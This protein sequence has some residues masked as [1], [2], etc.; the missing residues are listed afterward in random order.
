MEFRVEGNYV[1]QVSDYTIQQ[2]ATPLAAGDSFGGT[3]TVS[4]SIA[5][6]DPEIPHRK[7]T[8]SR[9]LLDSGRNILRGKSYTLTT[10]WGVMYGRIESVS[11]DSDGLLQISAFT[12]LNKLNSFNVQAKPFVGTLGDLIRYYCSLG[13]LGDPDID[14]AIDFRP[15]TA[16]GWVGELWY[17]LKML[18]TAEEFQ[19]S[20]QKNRPV[21]ELIRQRDVVKGREVSSAGDA[22]VGSLAQSIQCYLYNTKA[23]SNKL[24]YPP[25]GWN[26]T[27]E[28]LNVNA[29]EI[30][31]YTL[32]LSSS[33][34]S[35]QQPVM[36]ESVDPNY[37]TSSVFTV[38]AN[39]GLVVSPALWDARGGSVKVSIN[40]DTT[41][42]K[43]RIRGADRVPLA[44]GE[45]AS[46]FSIALASDTTSSRYSTLRIVGTGVS[47]KKELKTFPTGVPQKETGTEVGL[48]IDNPFFST[49]TNCY[50]A[51]VRAALS[52]SGVVPTLNTSMSKAFRSGDS[53]GLVPGSRTFDRDTQR[54]YRA[55]SATFTE[56]E[57][58][59]QWTDD[60]TY[61]DQQAFRSGETYG[62]VTDKRAGMSYQDDYL[63][64]LR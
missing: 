12:E 64:G 3:G 30:A 53:L 49:K 20:L 33:V 13:S 55:T 60:L 1:F 14:P 21:F 6:P 43:I 25:G 36:V 26:P 59:V 15:V 11:T 63:M 57:I 45:W 8:G 4:I 29:G 61:D 23:I 42:L 16:P 38:V 9:W 39:D 10:R 27:V 31:E 19:I 22:P 17:Y 51:G 7:G 18:A 52:Y 56:G 40:P 54:P 34:S 41:S 44:T 2:D 46:N 48:S 24:V 37:A 28:V 5:K 50:R 58:S 35:I 32:E 47:F 62:S